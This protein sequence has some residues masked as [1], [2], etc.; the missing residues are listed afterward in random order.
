MN[1]EFID[2][3]SVPDIINKDQFYRI[4]HISKSTA[5]HLLN[6]GKIPCEYSGKKT[7]CYRIRKEDVREYMNE[8]AVFPELYSAPQGWYGGHYRSFVP[9]EM[10]ED[11]LEMMRTYYTELL[12]KYRDVLTTPDIV[13]LTG[14]GRTAV[15]NWCSKGLL[16]NFQKGN[17]NHVP[18]VF[19]VNF[20]CSLSFRSITRKTPWHIKTLQEFQSQQSSIAFKLQKTKATPSAAEKGG[21]R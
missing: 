4:C 21:E 3:D 2:W 7:R 20:F 14:Y 9:K 13:K 15:N 5:L 6:S 8:R 16:R 17:I 18:K 12:A 10:P 1:N 11:V 19:L